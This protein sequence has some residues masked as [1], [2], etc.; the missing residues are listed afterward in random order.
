VSCTAPP[1]SSPGFRSQQWQWRPHTAR[2]ANPPSSGSADIACFEKSTRGG[3]GV[4]Y[5]ALQE[6]T[7][8]IVALKVLHGGPF[9]SVSDQARMEREVAL[10]A[11]LRHPNIVTIHDKGVAGGAT[12]FVM[13]YIDGAP[14]DRWAKS[15]GRSTRAGVRPI[16]E[17]FTKVC[18]AVHAAPSSGVIHR[19]LKPSNILVTQSAPDRG[20]PACAAIPRVLDFGLAKDISGAD[21]GSMTGDGQFVGSLPWASP[22]Q[23][24][25]GVID[26]RHRR[27]LARRH[28]VPGVDGTLP[29]VTS[30]PCRSHRQYHDRQPGRPKRFVPAIDTDLRDLRP[31]LPPKEPAR[32]YQSAGDLARDLQRYLARRTH[33]RARDSSSTSAQGARRIAA[34]R[35]RLHDF[36]LPRSF[37]DIAWTQ[38]IHHRE[39]AQRERLAKESRP[40]RR[41]RGRNRTARRRSPRQQAATRSGRIQSSQRLSTRQACPVGHELPCGI[42]SPDQP[43]HHSPAE[44]T[45]R[46]FLDP[47]SSE[48]SQ[49][50]RN[51]PEAEGG[52]RRRNGQAYASLGERRRPRCI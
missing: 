7:Q 3:Q 14:L 12:Y 51:D 50:L 19:D 20:E 9:A 15:V 27:L 47:A 38:A 29:Y 43:G 23:V 36:H 6:S 24:G 2:R 30:G 11:R 35:S 44:G 18:D 10:L 4:V 8:R 13:D 33:R 42:C 1:S 21:P 34:T 40:D 52:L 25:A 39:S 16:V 17:V 31:A 37:A 49:R 26:L 41:R 28:A 22:E 45:I 48:M 5:Q 32:R 46:E